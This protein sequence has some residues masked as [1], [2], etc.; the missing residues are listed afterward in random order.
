[1]K[2]TSGCLTLLLAVFLSAGEVLSVIKFVK[3]DF[4]PSYKREIVYGVGM[5]TGLGVIIGYFNI[6]DS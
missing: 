4:K 5:V 2:K 6:K 3:S 1:M